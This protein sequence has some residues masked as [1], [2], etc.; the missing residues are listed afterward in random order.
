MHD[1]CRVTRD[2]PDI[3]SQNLLIFFG[4]TGGRMWR[5]HKSAN[6]RSS[7]LHR[8]QTL[9]IEMPA[10]RPPCHA[11]RLRDTREEI[12]A[13]HALRKCRCKKLSSTKTSAVRA[14]RLSAIPQNH[15][16]NTP[17][18]PKPHL[19]RTG[20]D[21]VIRSFVDRDWAVTAATG[22]SRPSLT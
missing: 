19:V 5:S 3:G 22:R 14:L 18:R 9:T 10:P 16:R 11:A 21:L 8:C 7:F 2:V 13:G 6:D 15:L 1:V 4:M 17:L 20:R 12:P